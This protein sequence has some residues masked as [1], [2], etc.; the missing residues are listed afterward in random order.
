MNLLAL[1]FGQK[2]IGLALSIKGVTFPLKTVK[3][4]ITTFEEIRKVCQ[5][6][7]IEKL[8]VGLS[9]G[10][11]AQKTLSFVE[12]LEKML[13]LPIETVDETLTTQESWSHFKKHSLK[14]WK[15]QKDS[16]SAV[17]LLERI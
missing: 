4:N 17:R 14:K 16:L 2:N 9:S 10:Q 1:D 5:E 12:K 13:K 15:A 11:M 3:N 8:I 7:Q 6:Y